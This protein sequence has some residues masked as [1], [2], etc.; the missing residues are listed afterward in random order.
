MAIDSDKPKGAASSLVE[1]RGQGKSGAAD[2][3][4]YRQSFLGGA[5]GWAIG[6]LGGILRSEAAQK[7][8]STVTDAATR[9]AIGS[10]TGQT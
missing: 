6:E 10:I 4:I 5:A 1:A 7:T 3:A 8:L 2:N 9:A